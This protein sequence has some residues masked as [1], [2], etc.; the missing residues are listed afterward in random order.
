MPPSEPG[1]NAHIKTALHCSF[2]FI[3]GWTNCVMLL[4]YRCFATMMVGN[5]V[6]MGVAVFCQ[7]N[8]MDGDLAK[9]L[10]PAQF[11]STYYLKLIGLYLLGAFVYGLAEKKLGWTPRAFAPVIIVA[12]ITYKILQQAEVIRD[13]KFDLYLLAPI[14]GIAGSVS[15]KGG[16][17]GVPWAA[18]GNMLN[19]AY[20]AASYLDGVKE[21]D[22]QRCL[23]SFCLWVSMVAGVI[24]GT[25]FHGELTLVLNTLVLAVLFCLMSSYLPK[26]KEKSS[27]DPAGETA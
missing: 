8:L 26:Q 24:V 12:V 9:E 17:G 25:L 10:C 20:H 13:Y 7:D 11:E 27:E 15:A 4:R 1:I 2:A 18:T 14:F 19:I 22:A 23:V 5:T 6:L 21:S 16:I 3:I